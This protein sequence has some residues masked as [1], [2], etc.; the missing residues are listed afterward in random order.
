MCDKKHNCGPGKVNSPLPAHC[1]EVS[2]PSSCTL[3]EGQRP[4]SA[5]R[6]EASQLLYYALIGGQ[7]ASLIQAR[8]TVQSVAI[9]PCKNLVNETHILTY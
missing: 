3:Q 1:R 4:L 5:S 9:N 2:Q 8:A 6:R 7:Q